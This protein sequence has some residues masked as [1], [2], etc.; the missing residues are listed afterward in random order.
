V[1]L[2]FVHRNTEE[3]T[4]FGGV[5]RMSAEESPW[6]V[7]M[8]GALPDGT[9]RI[10]QAGM[11]NVINVEI[12]GGLVGLPQV[13]LFNALMWRVPVDDDSHESFQAWLLP[14]R[15]EEADTY[16]KRRQS[17]SGGGASPEALVA[18]VLRGERHTDDL[19]DNPQIIN[20]QDTVAQL[21][22]GAIADRAHERL[23]R[24]DAAIILWRKLWARELRALAEGRTL[25]QW[26]RSAELCARVAGRT[27]RA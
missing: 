21:G 24:S 13:G 3:V 9:V 2:A 8:Y 5:P 23:G 17:R 26:T 15:D 10:T 6:G 11:P 18:A 4:S 14:L 20:I 16:R 27:D 22:Q 19:L 12:F 25:R 1:H 7:T